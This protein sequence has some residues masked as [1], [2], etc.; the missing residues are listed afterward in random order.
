MIYFYQIYNTI[1]KITMSFLKGTKITMSFLKI[2]KITMSFFKN[3][4][5]QLQK[6][7][8]NKSGRC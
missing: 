3:T 7:Q 4:K 2:Q 6:N 1:K 8:C 5:N